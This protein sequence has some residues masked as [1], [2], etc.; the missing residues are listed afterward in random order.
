MPKVAFSTTQDERGRL[1]RLSVDSRTAYFHAANT[2]IN[3]RV[4]GEAVKALSDG[5]ATTGEFIQAKSEDLTASGLS[6]LANEAIT[7]RIKPAFIA[8]QRA[9]P[10]AEADL[11]KRMD[12]FTAPFFTDD[13]PPAVRVELRQYARTLPLPN[14]VGATQ[15]D[16]SLA[17]AVVEGGAAMS[18]LPPDVFDRLKRDMA[19]ANATRVLSGQ[20]DFRTVADASDPIGGKPNPTAARAAGE[21]LISALEA[22]HELL[23]EAPNALTAIIDIVAIMTD[24]TRDASFTLLTA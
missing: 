12:M 20:R 14:L 22:E 21:A 6:K 11:G 18:R 16:P 23:A 1:T 5:L 2:M 19:V 15:S 7:A 10:A 13:Q 8:T 17:A 9:I 4:I 24:T 3:H